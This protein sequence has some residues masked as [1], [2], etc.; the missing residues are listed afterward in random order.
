M[1]YAEHRIFITARV[2]I[3]D[4]IPEPREMV[5]G[6]PRGRRDEQVRVEAVDVNADGVTGLGHAEHAHDRS[7]TMVGPR[8]VG[9]SLSCH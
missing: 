3:C 4:S 8:H 5:L 7:R 2:S 1:I 6:E 9:P